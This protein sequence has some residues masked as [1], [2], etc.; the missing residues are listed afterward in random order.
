MSQAAH[1]MRSR[2]G[3]AQ[4]FHDKGDVSMHVCNEPPSEVED[5]AADIGA[6]QD[7]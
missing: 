1:V 7:Q 3:M 6:F 4:E 5:D 2:E